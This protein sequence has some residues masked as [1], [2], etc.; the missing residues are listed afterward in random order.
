MKTKECTLCQ[1]VK[2]LE[3]FYHRKDTNTALPECKSCKSQR[4][5]AYYVNNKEKGIKTRKI[6]RAANKER[7]A[8]GSKR[9][10]K[11]NKE[12]HEEYHRLY[13]IENKEIIDKWIT[14][15]KEYI[16]EKRVKRVPDD[17]VGKL[18]KQSNLP[19][20]PDLIEIRRIQI[21]IFRH[22]RL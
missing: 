14:D 22:G 13:R 11:A 20:T 9:W 12:K 6:Y 16:R 17:Y 15:N 3:D 2:P 5:A 18:L 7:I 19:I 8:A 4:A 1:E 10:V 21:K